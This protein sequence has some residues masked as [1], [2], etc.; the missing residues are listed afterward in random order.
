MLRFIISGTPTTTPYGFGRDCPDHFGNDLV[1]QVSV[2]GRGYENVRAGS[3][4]RSPVACHAHSR[5][6]LPELTAGAY[7][8]AAVTIENARPV[9]RVLIR[10]PF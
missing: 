7:D 2:F 5:K 1:A 10:V 4:I 3:S 9:N 6:G 8:D